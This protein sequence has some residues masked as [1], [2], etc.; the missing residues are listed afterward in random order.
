MMLRK[1]FSL[2]A[3]VLC[4]T[5]TFAGSASAEPRHWP[6]WEDFKALHVSSDARVIDTG[7]SRRITTSEGQSYALFFALVAGDEALFDRLL[8]WTE[9]NL[10][11]GD[12]TR[13]LPAWLW[14]R[15]AGRWQTLDT[16]NATDSDMWIAYALLEAGRLFDRPDYSQKARA[17]LAL[18]KRDMREVP[19][20][21]PVILP[22]GRGFEKRSGLTVNPSYWPVFVLRRFALEDP[23]WAPVA[24]ASRRALLRTSPKGLAPEWAQIDSEGRLVPARAKDARTGSYNAVR[25]YLWAGMMDDA[26]PAK[27]ELTEHFAPMARLTLALG[28]VPER[29]D[30]VDGSAEGTGSAGFGACL[31]AMLRGT[32][33]ADL[34]RARIEREGILPESYYRNTLILF[35]DGFDKG[36][37]RFD[38]HGR[39]DVRDK[40]FAYL[41]PRPSLK[42]TSDAVSVKPTVPVVE[43]PAAPVKAPEPP[44]IP[45]P[46]PTPQQQAPAPAA[47]P[48]EVPATPQAKETP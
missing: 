24:A 39:L 21:G 33:K 29:V 16:N 5:A 22:A 25:V 48:S 1:T 34:L 43:V 9:N 30:V 19:H 37:W 2:F 26:D 11:A 3:S 41:K 7:D 38:R 13:R 46:T 45:E 40:A 14:G 4:L 47:V 10:A 15:G 18:L 8:A 42:H 35:G 12:I 6:L 36:L 44:A 17:M 20:L 28:S 27:R 31:L 23:D 32:R